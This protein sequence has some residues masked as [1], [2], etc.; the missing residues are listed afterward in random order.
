MARKAATL[1]ELQELH[2]L[3]AKSLNKRITQDMEDEIPTDAA[4]QSPH[5][6]LW[7]DRT[8]AAMFITLAD[9]RTDAGLTALVDAGMLTAER[10]VEIIEAM[11]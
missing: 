11:Q 4:T 6:K 10:K 5:V 1:G 9:P 3:I 2:S 8:R 7:Y